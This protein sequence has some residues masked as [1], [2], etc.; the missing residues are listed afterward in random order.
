MPNYTYICRSCK[1]TE[2]R[3]VP[4]AKRYDQDCAKCGKPLF[5][6]IEAAYTG[7]SRFP[8]VHNLLA[9]E[10]VL[11]TSPRQEAEEFRKRGVINGN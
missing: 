8:Y 3:C 9:P 4:I 5:K 1:T 2:E 6:T 7:P 11:M 10:P